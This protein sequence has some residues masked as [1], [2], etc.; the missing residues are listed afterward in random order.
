MRPGN[1]E[2]RGGALDFELAAGL[3]LDAGGDPVAHP[4]GRDEQIDGNEREHG[5][6]DTVPPTIS[7]NLVR[8]L[9]FAELGGRAGW[10]RLAAPCAAPAAPASAEG[11]RV[12]MG[13]AGFCAELYPEK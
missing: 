11:D 3:L 2:E 9:H 5:D 12:G 1:E 13:R 4:I 10:L 7:S 8:G 6:A